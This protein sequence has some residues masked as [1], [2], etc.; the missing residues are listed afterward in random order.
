MS[1]T[2]VT[3][4]TFPYSSEAQIVKGRL[5]SEG[6]EA[7]LAD[8]YTIDTDPLVS[9]AIGGVKLRVPKIQE[10]Q[11]REIL[12]SIEA[13]AVD[14]EGEAIACPNC[15]SKKLQLFTTIT[16][17]KSLGAFL[18]GFFFG[19]LPFYT[20]YKYICQECRHKFNEV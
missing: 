1:E 5:L 4:A 10:A 15:S 20:K 17:V 19:A 9:V 8:N 7:F 3:V 11:A 2:F 12:Q 14:D 16:D 18:L 13:F 6:I